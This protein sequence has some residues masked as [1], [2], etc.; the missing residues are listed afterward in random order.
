[1]TSDNL[2]SPDT[3]TLVLGLQIE[4]YAPKI[5]SIAELRDPQMRDLFKH[6]KMDH[7][8][9]ESSLIDSIL[10]GDDSEEKKLFKLLDYKLLEKSNKE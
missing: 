7:I 2:T 9:W 4:R 8:I 10:K 5:V 6:T 3:Y 1:M